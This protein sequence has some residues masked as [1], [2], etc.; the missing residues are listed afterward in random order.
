MSKWEKHYKTFD[1]PEEYLDYLRMISDIH[2]NQSEY[3]AGRNWNTSLNLLS[4]GETTHLQ[5]AQEIIDKVDVSDLIANGVP[6]LGPCVAGFIPNIPAAISG[7]P[8]SMF[9]RT[10]L[11]SPSVQ[12]PLSV[13]VETTV[14]SGV[15]LDE[16]LQRGIATLAFVLAMEVVRPVDLYVVSLVSHRNNMRGVYGAVTKVASRPMDIT[17]AVYM[18]TD[19]AYARRFLHSSSQA[20]HTWSMDSGPWCFDSNPSHERYTKEIREFLEMQPEDVYLKGG[21]LHDKQMLSNPVQWVQDMITK[22]SGQT[23]EG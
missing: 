10:L 9:K 4:N 1:S 6:V 12:S 8:E 13:Y 17:R 18:L 14:S 21:H 15:S 16:L 2:A 19:A 22:H 23:V 5:R 7:H 11:D 20:Q 3:W